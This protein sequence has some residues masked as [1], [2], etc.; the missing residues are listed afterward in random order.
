MG[1][2]PNSTAKSPNPKAMPSSS[3]E[4]ADTPGLD[5][6]SS[7]IREIHRANFEEQLR[8][9]DREMGF[10]KENLDVLKMAENQS[11]PC[12][13][14]SVIIPSVVNSPNNSNRTPLQ[15]LSN[16]PTT[17]VFKPGSG[18]WK[19][20]ARAKGNGPGPLF[21]PLTE[22]RPRDAMLIDSD[23]E[24][25]CR[26]EKIQHASPSE[27]VWTSDEGCENTIKE[28]W[29]YRV[30]GTAMFK[31]ANKLTQ[32]K[33]GLGNWSRRM[34]G[35]ISKQ[36]AEKKRLLKSAEI[37]AV[38]SGNMSSVKNLKME[39]NSLLDQIDTAVRYVPKAI[40]QSMNDNLVR[41]FSAG[42]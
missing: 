33:R 6:K 19:K 17:K 22:K 39:V 8:E 14:E 25:I 9:I 23:A 21:L 1:V 41:E 40:S 37:E 5:P 13:P 15:E 20:K 10:L 35:N 29:E 11:L 4:K 24:I 18:S 30:D 28:S 34:F 16:A 7:E 32:C 2:P 26:P 3:K 31:V 36:L 38:R 42:E 27:E 12:V